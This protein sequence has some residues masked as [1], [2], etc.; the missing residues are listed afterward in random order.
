[1]NSPLGNLGISFATRFGVSRLYPC[2][3]LTMI[4]HLVMTFTVRH[5]KIHHAIKNG[6]PSINQWAIHT[7]A[8]LVIT[9]GYPHIDEIWGFNGDPQS[10]P[11][12]SIPVVMVIHVLDDARGYP[13]DKTD[14]STYW[15]LLIII[16]Y[17]IDG[18]Y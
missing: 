11:W 15:H 13:H 9:R 7:M 8:M 1:M 5:G 6:K 10:S 18:I 3:D 17:K 4:Y 12:L 14:T 2:R 16:K